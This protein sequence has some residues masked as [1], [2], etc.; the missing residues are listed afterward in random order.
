[1]LCD[2]TK[3]TR[4]VSSVHI[5]T[6]DFRRPA[7]RNISA[8]ILRERQS[9]RFRNSVAPLHD[10]SASPSLLNQETADY[11]PLPNQTLPPHW[12]GP[13]RETKSIALECIQAAG[14]NNFYPGEVRTRLDYTRLISFYDPAYT[15]LL[16]AR[17][18]VP[19]DRH[20]LQNISREDTQM[21][22]GQLQADLLRVD[23]KTSGIDWGALA[24]AVTD[25]Y[26]DRLFLLNSTL[27]I[28]KVQETN[29]TT[30][31][32]ATRRH[33][34]V[35]LTPYLVY[36]ALPDGSSGGQNASWVEPI[37]F[38]CRSSLTARISHASLARSERLIKGAIEGVLERICS[39]LTGMWVDAFAV[40][41]VSE[42]Q[43]AELVDKWRAEIKGLMVWLD[44]TMWHVCRPECSDE[45]C[46]VYEVF[47]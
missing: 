34:M 2:F 5:M 25:R 1:M 6:A 37:T 35:M 27:A 9:T 26:A 7:P 31:A 44:W 39:S 45:V 12:Q 32:V 36:G 46:E 38:H 29:A 10:P 33:L 42:L 8:D 13:L 40:G 17:E 41:S 24:R 3:K 20:R 43:A 21:A 19:R 15:S 4:L 47:L 16:A 23:K 22:V 14:W 30:V 11:R 28:T 18:G